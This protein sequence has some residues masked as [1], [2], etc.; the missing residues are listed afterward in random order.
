V[1]SS[2][3]SIFIGY[4]A[5]ILAWLD[6]TCCELIFNGF[7]KYQILSPNP[8]VVDFDFT[9]KCMFMVKICGKS[10]F[11]AREANILPRLDVTML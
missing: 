7:K 2:Q 4:Q 3:N 1:K 6:D 10:V 11:H 5:D 9:W 8:K